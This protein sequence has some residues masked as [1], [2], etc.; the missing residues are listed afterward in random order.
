MRSR[1][2]YIPITQVRPGEQFVHHGIAYVR[3]TEQEDRKHPARELA[4]RRGR[5]LVFAYSTG[6]ERTPVSFVPDLDVYVE[7]GK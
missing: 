5:P 7:M 2:R 6:K 4:K 1:M 3:A